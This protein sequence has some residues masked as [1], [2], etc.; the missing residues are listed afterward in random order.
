MNSDNGHVDLYEQR[1]C[2]KCLLTAKELCDQVD[3]DKQGEEKRE[4]SGDLG[5]QRL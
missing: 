4:G 5:A 2:L 3:V 1:D